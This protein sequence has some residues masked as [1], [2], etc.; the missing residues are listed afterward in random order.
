M[1]I[2]E[3]S[4]KQN[5]GIEPAPH[6]HAAMSTRRLMVYLLLS[7]IPAL[8]V[9]TYYFGC[10]TLWQFIICAVTAV[11]CQVLSAFLRSR[12]IK[13]ALK[14]PSGIVTALLLA[15]TLPPL[16]PWHFTLIAIIFAMLIARECFGGLGMNLFNPAMAGFI[17]LVIS[18]PSMFYQTWITPAP[19]A[20]LIATPV[21][22]AQIIFGDED[23]K[24][25]VEEIIALNTSPEADGN[26]YADVLTGAT[27]LESNKTA[28]K[29]GNVDKL[30][31]LDFTSSSFQAYLA[32]AIAY[33]VG[34]L[35]LIYL[36]VIRFQVPL[37]FLLTL[38]GVG[39]L[40]HH[41]D[42]TM[43]INGVEHLLLGG[44]MLGA[45]YIVTDP[46]TTCG[47]FKGRILFAAFI[48]CLVILI[49]IKGSYSDS[50]AFAVLLGNCVAPLIDV[51]TKRR[52]FGIGYRTG[53]LD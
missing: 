47:T 8:G 11:A 45:F 10:G 30:V 18:V 13:S 43:S 22:T 33:T 32:L 9:I 50:V 46:V 23:P 53:G 31:K 6:V 34:G 1:Q 21:R 48:A 26:T 14:D 3:Q 39:A 27:F 52:P 51:L 40:W 49:R 12:S 4:A 28:R 41:L 37:T 24:L 15:I 25:L 7:L 44:S 36:R 2:S 42:P 20:V 16:L 19:Q 17:F 35:A 38:F 29:A 5:L